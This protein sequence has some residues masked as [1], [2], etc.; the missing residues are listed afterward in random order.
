VKL[1]ETKRVWCDDVHEWELLI[2]DY[3]CMPTVRMWC[4]GGI[5]A[6]LMILADGSECESP[7]EFEPWPEFIRCRFAE[8]VEVARAMRKAVR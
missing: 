2:D 4:D 5:I 8:A 7:R 3:E 1:L 6:K